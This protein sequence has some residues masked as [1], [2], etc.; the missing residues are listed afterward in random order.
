[1]DLPV[2]RAA[3]GGGGFLVRTFGTEVVILQHPIGNV[4]FTKG[5]VHLLYAYLGLK[6]SDISGRGTSLLSPVLSSTS[7]PLPFP[8]L[9]EGLEERVASELFC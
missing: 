1:M 4:S 8:R 2:T 5:A 6:D 3:K 7:Y 9:N